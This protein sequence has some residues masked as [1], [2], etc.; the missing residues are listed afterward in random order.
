METRLATLSSQLNKKQTFLSAVAELSTMGKALFN[1]KSPSEKE[2]YFKVVTRVFTVLQTR[3]T[4]PLYWKAGLQLFQE[5]LSSSDKDKKYQDQLSKYLT[6]C[7]IHVEEGVLKEIQEERKTEPTGQG[8]SDIQNRTNRLLNI[9]ASDEGHPQGI[10]AELLSEIFRDVQIDELMATLAASQ[11]ES[12]SI[13]ASRDARENL[14]L[15]TIDSGGLTCVVCQ[16]EFPPNSKAKQLP[17]SHLFH[18]HC[19]E[20]WLEKNNTCPVCRFQLP[21]EKMHFDD[22]SE[23]IKKRDPKQ[24]GSLYS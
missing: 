1:G 7:K 5:L 4:E 15:R 9:I 16:D 20:P 2:V 12:N 13:P 11:S 6:S 19:V 21:S 17:C 18:E 22:L 10:P 23:K 14:P 3:Y 24:L 8:H